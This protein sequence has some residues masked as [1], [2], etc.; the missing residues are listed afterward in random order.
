MVLFSFDLMYEQITVEKAS[1]GK[2]KKK[3]ASPQP[4]LLACK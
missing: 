4:L 2:R 1:L 3:Q